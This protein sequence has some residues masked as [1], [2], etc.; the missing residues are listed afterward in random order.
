MLPKRDLLK[1]EKREILARVVEIATIVAM[2][3]HVYSFE[4]KLFIQRSGG[5][6]GMRSI[7]NLANLV[8]RKY[9]C[10][11]LALAKKE[12]LIIDSY[13]RYVDDCRIILPSLNKGWRWVMPL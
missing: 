1:C 7:A 10:A 5:P 2:G 9:D 4:D 13:S 11:W 3:T 8:M 12:G 6:I